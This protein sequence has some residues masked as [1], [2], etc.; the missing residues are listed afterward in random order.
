[1]NDTVIQ[2]KTGRLVLRSMQRRRSIR[3]AIGSSVLH[4]IAATCM[5]TAAMQLYCLELGASDLYL[6]LV[7]CSIWAGAPFLLLGISLMK[8]FGK[9]RI[10]VFWSGWLPAICMA[11]VALL[12][13]LHKAGVL[14]AQWILYWLLAALLL[15][16]ISDNIGAAGWFPVLHDNVP[17]R[18]TGK[19]FATFRVYWQISVLASTLLIAWFLGQS[20]AWWKFCVVFA[21]GEVC[22]ILKTFCLKQLREKPIPEQKP[23]ELSP[24]RVLKQAVTDPKIGY[25]LG[26]IMLYN[27]AVY[28]CLP[29]QI[30]YLKNL[31]YSEGYIMA[32][33]AMI[34]LGAILSLPFWGRLAD[35]FG[36]RSVFNFSH[37]GIIVVLAGWIVVDKNLFSAVFVFILYGLWSVFQS[38]NGI[39][40]TRYMF[41]SV[42]EKDQS[43][44]VIINACLTLSIALAPLTSGL[45]LWLCS[46]LHVASGALSMNQYHMLFVFSALLVIIPHH[47]HK[48]F[49]SDAETPAMEVFVVVTRPLLTLFGSFVSFPRNKRNSKYPPS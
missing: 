33:N 17:S 9:R 35:R 42:S 31:G 25:F 46:E 27:L 3:A 41:H 44:I 39:A 11:C 43:N 8:K 12:P 19:F 15:R 2:T 22:F 23:D 29:F 28:M 34:S 14:S 10:L 47:M 4:T 38:A 26:Y 7:T 21:V 18:I 32:A 30:K 13:L 45:F 36:N 49:Q 16:S 37:I 5:L 24:W 20:P 48:R 1:M 40:Q 6:G